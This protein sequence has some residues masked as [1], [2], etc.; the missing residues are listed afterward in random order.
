MAVVAANG[1]HDLPDHCLAIAAGL[2]GTALA[3]NLVRPA[4]FYL[5]LCSCSRL[6]P[7]LALAPC[8]FCNVR[9]LTI[10]GRTSS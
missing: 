8:G 7:V 2:V 4:Q 9:H 6:F 10:V 3:L 1:F 5:C